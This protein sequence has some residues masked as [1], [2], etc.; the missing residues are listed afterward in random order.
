VS[1][2]ISPLYREVE[3]EEDTRV[4][5]RGGAGGGGRASAAEAAGD[6]SFAYGVRASVEGEAGGGE[7]GGGKVAAA[8]SHGGIGEGEGQY[9]K[10]LS[11]RDNGRGGRGRRGGEGGGDGSGG[12][13]APA[14]R[15]GAPTARS[16]GPTPRS[17]I[18][19]LSPRS[20]GSKTR[21][22]SLPASQNL[23]PR[24]PVGG[25]RSGSGGAA[26]GVASQLGGMG[27]AGAVDGQVGAL[28]EGRGGEADEAY[29]EDFDEFDESSVTSGY[30]VS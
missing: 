27:A 11:P 10:A 18:A 13:G 6:W 14:S 23:S 12:V 26:V 16:D 30:E 20:Q 7:V 24:K 29:D 3:V 5:P 28:G 8:T 25:G 22:P 4:V 17:I 2:R 15:T 21:V 9:D 1:G 19:G